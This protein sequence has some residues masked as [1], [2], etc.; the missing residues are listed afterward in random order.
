[1]AV[2]GS[3]LKLDTKNLK[4]KALAQI[5][6]RN[7]DLGSWNVSKSQGADGSGITSAERKKEPMPCQ[8]R[9]ELISLVQ[10]VRQTQNNEPMSV[11]SS[12]RKRVVAPQ[13]VDRSL[14]YLT[15]MPLLSTGNFLSGTHLM[16]RGMFCP[17]IWTM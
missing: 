3:K 10:E 16:N 5:K 2:E 14:T 15:P 17:I 7:N 11:L 9:K 6:T 4:R 12:L 8:G 13:N 1:M